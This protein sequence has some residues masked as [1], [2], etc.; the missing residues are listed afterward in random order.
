MAMTASL[1]RGRNA[2]LISFV[3]LMTTHKRNE[4]FFEHDEMLRKHRVANREHRFRG[5]LGN[6][7]HFYHKH[8]PEGCSQYCRLQNKCILPERFLLTYISIKKLSQLTSRKSMFFAVSL[9]AVM[10][11]SG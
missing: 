11:H 2:K 4:G 6:N 9:V 8:S 10:E 5:N 7:I 1:K 3:S